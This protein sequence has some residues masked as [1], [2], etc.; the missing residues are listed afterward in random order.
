MKFN[1][2]NIFIGARNAFH[3]FYG[4]DK[5]QPTYVD[6]PYSLH[7]IELTNH[8]IA[9]C[10]MCPR[11]IHM[12]RK[13]GYMDVDLFKSIIDQYKKDNPSAFCGSWQGTCLHHFGESLLHPHFDTC[14]AYAETNGLSICISC[15]AV[16]LTPDKSERLFKA[17]PSVIYACLDGY[18]NNSLYHI[19]GLKNAYDISV[20]N[21]LTAFELKEKFSP[22][23][24]L[25]LTM[26]DIPIYYEH[27]N[28]ACSWWK[29]Q[30]GI[31][32]FRKK[33]TTWNGSDEKINALS[34]TTQ[35][36]RDLTC[37][38]PEEITSICTTPW[39]HLSICYDGDIVPCCRDYN[40]IYSLGNVKTNKISDVF[41]SSK[42]KR[43]RKEIQSKKVKN[44]LC[45]F[46][47]RTMHSTK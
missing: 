10:I 31:D 40:N 41:N 32:V 12:T 44:P 42:M 22:A 5:N 6:A 1:F 18:D 45:R 8:C 7:N 33:F 43:L 3:S 15:N 16:A 26:I 23:T 24:Q 35:E 27:T 30:H 14:V 46:C 21:I 9:H 37:D 39:T 25:Y 47:E 4:D 34:D 2:K 29:T 17:K 38:I 28:K 11:E 20:E 19:R 36:I 13:K